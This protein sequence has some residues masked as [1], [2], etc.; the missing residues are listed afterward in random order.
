MGKDTTEPAAR[1][2]YVGQRYQPGSW[3]RPRLNAT[4]E[5]EHNEELTKL[6]SSATSQSMKVI[7]AQ[8]HHSARPAERGE[9]SASASPAREFGSLIDLSVEDAYR[10]HGVRERVTCEGRDTGSTSK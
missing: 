3:S 7:S 1:C 2:E 4:Q 9:T 6:K 8:S 5:Y 10:C